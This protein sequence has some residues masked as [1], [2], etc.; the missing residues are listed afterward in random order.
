MLKSESNAPKS[1]KYAGILSSTNVL[2]SMRPQGSSGTTLL[3]KNA[4]VTQSAS[5]VSQWAKF[6]IPEQTSTSQTS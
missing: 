5:P 2:E 3:L 4:A 6:T 1:L